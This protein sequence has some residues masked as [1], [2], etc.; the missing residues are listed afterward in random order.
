MRKT[1]LIAAATLAVGVISSQAAG[2][3]SQNIVG[4]ANVKAEGGH[5]TMIE[6]P[7]VIGASNGVN[8]VFGETLPLYSFVLIYQSGSFSTAL[9]DNG[10]GPGTPEWYMADDST[11]LDGIGG[12]PKLPCVPPGVGFFIYVNGSSMT[13][14]FA[15]AV[16]VNVGTSNS[17]V[18]NAGHNNA[19]GC[20]VP[21]AGYVTNG[22]PVTGAGGPNINVA[23]LPLYSFFLFYGPTHSFT[24]ALF[25]NGNGS[26]TPE[27]YYA[28]D[29]T[30]YVDPATGGNEPTITVGQGY[31]LYPNGPYTWVTGL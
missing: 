5:N 14:T 18:L 10:N 20:A 16:A 4:Y 17:M 28:D 12:D 6:V 23:T 3:Y 11:P 7:F 13:N 2:V 8:E 21:Y 31:F 22:N 30:P 29:S 15:G 24:T 25:D 27:W 26:G 1:L 9:F 19:V